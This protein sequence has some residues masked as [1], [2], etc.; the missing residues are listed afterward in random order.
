MNSKTKSRNTAIFLVIPVYKRSQGSMKDLQ[1]ANQKYYMIITFSKLIS[2]AYYW[3][4]LV[5]AN[6]L[7]HCHISPKACKGAYFK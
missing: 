2:F 1:C 7:K 3:R 4:L 5:L 6:S